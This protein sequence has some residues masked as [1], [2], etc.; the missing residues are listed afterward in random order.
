MT[1]ATHAHAAEIATFAERFAISP[2]VAFVLPAVFERCAQMAGMPVRAFVSAATFDSTE[3]G[4][5]VAE[6]AAKVAAEASR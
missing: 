2:S 6:V 4:E 5:Y 1:N 3:L